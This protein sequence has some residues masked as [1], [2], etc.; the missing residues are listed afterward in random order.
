MRPEAG[1]GRKYL[2]L[3]NLDQ[4]FRVQIHIGRY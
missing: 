4:L 2:Y 1:P 3:D